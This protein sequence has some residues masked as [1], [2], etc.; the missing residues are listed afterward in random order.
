MPAPGARGTGSSGNRELREPRGSRSSENRVVRGTGSRRP[1]K[2]PGTAVTSTLRTRPHGAGPGAAAAGPGEPISRS[3]P[4]RPGR[5]SS[6]A[7]PAGS[8]G[9][10]S[11]PCRADAPRGSWTERLP[12]DPD[13]ASS[14]VVGPAPTAPARLG[15]VRFGSARFGSAQPGP[16]RSRSAQPARHSPARPLRPPRRLPLTDRRHPALAP[17][18]VSAQPITAPSRRITPP[19]LPSRPITARLLPLAPPPSAAPAGRVSQKW[20]GLFCQAGPAPR[21]LPAPSRCACALGRGR[22]GRERPPVPHDR[23]PCWLRLWPVPGP[24]GFPASLG[25]GATGVLRPP[26]SCLAGTSVPQ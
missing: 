10:S 16:A 17:P 22:R 2:V 25:Q 5:G 20:A 3:E 6:H 13:P 14:A 11:R 23:P 9:S 15:S 18:P 24:A 1:E 19:R 7:A 21:L 26:R 12:P 4:P 8:R